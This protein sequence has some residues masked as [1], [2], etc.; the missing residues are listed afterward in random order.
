MR[1][2]LS[3]KGK[4]HGRQSSQEVRKAQ[5]YAWRNMRRKAAMDIIIYTYRI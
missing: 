5:Q 3:E 4:V 1:L 2:L